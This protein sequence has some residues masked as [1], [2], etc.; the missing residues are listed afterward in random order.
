MAPRWAC[1]RGFD[2]ATLLFLL[3]CYSTPARF[4][5]AGEV[6]ALVGLCLALVDVD[7]SCMLHPPQVMHLKEIIAALKDDVTFGAWTDE[8]PK[9]SIYPM[10]RRRG[11]C[12]P[13]TRMW[14]WCPVKFKALDRN[15][16]LMV[17]YHKDVPTYRATLAEH[18]GSDTRTLAR[19]EYHG[20]DPVPG[21]HMHV[22][23]GDMSALETG[24]TK[25][26]NQFRTPS[27]HKP[28]RR[29]NYCRGEGQMTDDE[30]MEIALRRF[31]IP[32]QSDFFG[33]IKA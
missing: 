13:L 12:F 22:V 23:C 21:W 5:L 30:A 32:F 10:P 31:R 4:H 27:A 33:K 15:F 2:G 17:A 1:G 3:L 20:A 8:K 28:H 6:V 14:R 9:P 7:S 29:A 26:R 24:T 25:P 18:L 11:G 16:V 19:Y